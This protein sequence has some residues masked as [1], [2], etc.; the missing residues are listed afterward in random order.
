MGSQ[1]LPLKRPVET[2][3]PIC[4]GRPAET[5]T[6]ETPSPPPM[7]TP[8]M[9]SAILRIILSTFAMLLINHFNTPPHGRG[10]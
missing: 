8:E 6:A 9:K 7:R 10:L 3:M 1:N 4:G 2:S 5:V